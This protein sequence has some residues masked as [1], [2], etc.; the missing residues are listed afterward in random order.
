V[1]EIAS[2][3]AGTLPLLATCEAARIA[4]DCGGCALCDTT[5]DAARRG[6]LFVIGTAYCTTLVLYVLYYYSNLG[7]ENV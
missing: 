5:W 7:G 6:I 1:A 2:V 4:A 3:T